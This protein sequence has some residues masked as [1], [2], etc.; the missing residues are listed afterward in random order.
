[1]SHL[2]QEQRYIIEILKKEKYS[3]TAIAER[4]GKDKSVVCR[5]LKRNCDKRNAS[6]RG[7]LA[8]RRCEKRHSD[9]NKKILFTDQVKEYVTKWIK[10][11]YSPEQIVGKAKIEGLPCVSI[12]RIYQFIWEDKK[13]RGVLYTHLRTQGKR[14]RKR[15]ACKDKR[16]QII[17]RIGIEKRPIEVAEKDRLGDFEIDLVIGKD[18]KRALLTANDRSSG[19]SKI[20]KIDSK[21]S[22]LVKEAV[23]ELLY[24]FKPI[25][26]TITSDN[27]KEFAQHQE[28]AE[29]LAIGY[30]F[31][32]PYH[33]WE[34]GANENMNGLIRQY[35]PKG[36]SF[37]DITNE[38][39]QI[40]ED[41]LNNRPRKRFGFKSPNQV[42]LHKLTNQE[43]VAFIT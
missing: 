14:Y 40:V 26:K 29:E 22:K 9:K 7:S 23:V 8:H 11:D 43:K 36:T 12:E 41:K 28:I 6:Y 42:Y 18:H 25:L 4:I 37:E 34:R 38:Q 1:M 16:G 33:S 15:G 30:Y 20:K 3:Q 19:K 21:D 35:F 10:E 13:Q 5:E 2:T 32:R 31:A 27:G 24:E 17:G 39:V